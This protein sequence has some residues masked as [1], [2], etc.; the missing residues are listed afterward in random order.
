MN[1]NRNSILCGAVYVLLMNFSRLAAAQTGD[2]TEKMNAFRKNGA[3]HH[4]NMIEDK[5]G[6][7]QAGEYTVID[8]AG[9]VT[10]A[11]CPY[12]CADRGLP[13]EHCKSW[14]SA[15]EKQLC[16]LQDTRIPSDAM[17]HEEP[18]AAP[19]SKDTRN[20]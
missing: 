2:P 14:Q 3:A 12:V 6:E 9:S 18:A 13:A 4:Q 1:I 5:D 15:S 20:Q 11:N 19:A 10:R 16:Y 7:L 8:P 17:P